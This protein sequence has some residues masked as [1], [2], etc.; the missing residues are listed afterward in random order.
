MADSIL[1]KLYTGEEL[2][3]KEIQQFLF[4]DYIGD[5]KEI[6]EESYGSGRWTESMS[7][8]IRVGDDLW[9]VDWEHGL[10][11]YQENEFYKQPYRVEAVKKMIE[12]TEYKR[13][14]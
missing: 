1:T 13:I 9:C 4:G 6:D 12:V 7:T 11:E 14:E 2:N 5:Y 3:S 10:T 8:I